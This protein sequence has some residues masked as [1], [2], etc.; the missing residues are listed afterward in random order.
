MRRWLGIADK[1][2]AQVDTDVG[3][4]RVHNLTG[5]SLCAQTVLHRGS[6]GLIPLPVDESYTAWGHSS[7]IDHVYVLHYRGNPGRLAFQSAQVPQL[8]INA[9]V[10]AS[11][12]KQDLDGS[13]RSC[14]AL[15]SDSNSFGADTSIT[16]VSRAA[17]LSASIKLYVALYDM[18]RRA[19]NTALILE[20]DAKIVWNRLDMLKFAIA[21]TSL[22][23]A[24]NALR[25]LFAG[26]YNKGGY[27]FLCCNY[28]PGP[29]IY[30]RPRQ[31]RG[32]GMMSAVG[33]VVTHA[34]MKHLLSNL[35]IRDNNDVLLSVAATRTGNQPGL[36]YVKPYP[37]IPARDLQS[38]CINCNASVREA[39]RAR[40][41]MPLPVARNASSYRPPR[42]VRA[43]Q[44]APSQQP[45]EGRT[46]KSFGPSQAIGRPAPGAAVGRRAPLPQAP[47]DDIHVQMSRN[48]L[49]GDFCEPHG[50]LPLT[51]H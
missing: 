25:I 27:D 4:S 8:G 1:P 2:Q 44:V 37:F 22:A 39:M 50:K 18:A 21:N 46:N 30:L 26:S 38:E 12:D 33:V 36:W 17:Q 34:G 45:L 20:D 32:T 51:E 42:K 43:P 6:L 11:Y 47:Y 14:K 5:M 19:L 48:C 7:G 24:P 9:S 10:V 23:Q 31:F 41:Q 28:G 35:P 15:I 40:A 49:A 3:W 29:Y 13:L 16:D